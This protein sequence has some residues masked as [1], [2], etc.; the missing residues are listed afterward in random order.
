VLEHPA[1]SLAW[2]AFDLP[3]PPASGGWV[4]D[5]FSGLWACHVEQGHWGHYARKATWLLAAGIGDIP[6]AIWGRAET[7]L[8]PATV[9]RIGHKKASRRGL[10][11][12]GGGGD[13]WER[14]ATPPAFRD[15][16]LAIAATAKPSDSFRELESQ[17]A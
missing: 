3:K 9:A 12:K 15:Y 6:P 8:D 4:S 2:D 1:G 17:H 10:A 16:L 5:L 11:F 14:S 7:R 13:D